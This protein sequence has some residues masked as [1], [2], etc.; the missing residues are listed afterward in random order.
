[1]VTKVRTLHC[2]VPGDV[3]DESGSVGEC[4]EYMYSRRHGQ[5]QWLVKWLTQDA[6]PSGAV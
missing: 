4:A 2:M 3:P 1:M 6:R 5:L